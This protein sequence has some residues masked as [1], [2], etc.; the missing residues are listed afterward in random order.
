VGSMRKG[1]VTVAVW[2]LLTTVVTAVETVVTVEV[3]GMVSIVL[4]REK[5]GR[6]GKVRG[7]GVVVGVAAQAQGVR[8]KMGTH[9]WKE[10]GAHGGQVEV[11]G[12]GEHAERGAERGLVWRVERIVEAR[13]EGRRCAVERAA[14]TSA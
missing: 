8:R 13:A 11:V 9:G 3:V 10:W 6:V 14:A 2:L 5:V 4:R 7:D 1:V 12:W